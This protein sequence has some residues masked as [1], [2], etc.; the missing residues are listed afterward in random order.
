M[1]RLPIYPDTLACT[2]TRA[3][4][5]PVN[6]LP[7]GKFLCKSDL[8]P[9][10]YNGILFLLPQSWKENKNRKD[11]LTSTYWKYG[12]NP[13]RQNCS[14]T[15]L[16]APHSSGVHLPSLKHCPGFPILPVNGRTANCWRNVNAC[17]GVNIDVPCSLPAPNL[18]LSLPWPQPEEGATRIEEE[19][20]PGR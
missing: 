2:Y 1:T 6:G 16:I 18:W 14:S 11:P 13:L 5:Q 4:S 20:L 17:G 19:K 12:P 9:S 3:H 10:S 8:I 15:L 7:V